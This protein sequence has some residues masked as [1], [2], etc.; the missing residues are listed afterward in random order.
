MELILIRGL[1]GSGKSTYA[2]NL[3]CFHVEADMY[4]QRNG[5]YAFD[6]TNA[7]AAHEWCQRS[8]LLAMEKGMDVA[9][10]NT[11]TQLWEMKPYLDLASKTGHSVRVVRMAG[12]HGSIHAVPEEVIRKMSDRFEAFD[13]ELVVSI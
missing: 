8:A 7:K 12:S 3:G 11:F 9:V 13:S 2:K 1:P 4:H 6:K 5:R 10:S